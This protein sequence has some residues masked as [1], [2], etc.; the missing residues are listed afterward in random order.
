[1]TDDDRGAAGG[2]ERQR[3]LEADPALGLAGGHQRLGGRRAV[4]QDLEVDAGVVV[5]ALRL[6]R[7][8]SR[9]GSCSASSRARGGPCRAAPRTP[10]ATRRHGRRAE[11]RRRGRRR[12]G[13][14]STATPTSPDAARGRR[15]AHGAGEREAASTRYRWMG[16]GHRVSSSNMRNAVS[17][18]GDGVSRVDGPA[19]F[20]GT[21]RIR[22]RGS[23]AVRHTL[24]ARGA[25][26]RRYSVVARWYTVRSAPAIRATSAD[27]A[28]GVER[29]RSTSRSTSARVPGGRVDETSDRL[30]GRRVLALGLAAPAVL[31][32]DPTFDHVEPGPDGLQRRRHGPGRRHGRRRLRD[33]RHGD[34][35][36]RR[37]DRGRDRRPRRSSKAP[38]G[39]GLRGRRLARDRRRDAPS[40]G[41][42]RTLDTTV[43]ADPAATI[44]GSDGQPRCGPRSRRA[45]SSRRRSSCSCSGSSLVTIV[46]GL[47]L[48][49]L[50]ARQV[51]TA[52]ALI[53]REPGQTL[54][55]GLAGL[56]VV[57]VVAILAMIT[58]IGAPAR[59]GHPVHGLAG[60]RLRRLPRRRDLDRRMA[61]RPRRARRAPG[62]AVPGGRRRAARPAD[63]QPR[64]VR[65]RDRQPVRVRRRPA[66]GLADVP[67]AV[68]GTARSSARRR[69]SRWASDRLDGTAASDRPARPTA[70]APVARVPQ[71]GDDLVDDRR[72]FGL[73]V[74]LVAEARVGPALDARCAFEHVRGGRPGRARRP[75]RAGR[76]SGSP[77]PPPALAPDP[78]LLAS[79]SAPKRD[80]ADLDARA[81]RRPAFAPTVGS[82]DRVSPSM[83]LGIERGRRDAGQD[84]RQPLLPA[85][86]RRIERRR[87][88]HREVRLRPVGQEV[89]GGDQPTER[90]AVEH[91]RSPAASARDDR[92]SRS[93]RSSWSCDQRSTS[94]R[95]PP[96]PPMPRWS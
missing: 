47:A 2:G 38:G 90:V 7:R 89:A 41:D 88:E 72:A 67:P 40:R 70:G 23:V 66:P 24:S 28:R 81:G 58:I 29:S 27:D 96:E 4:R 62:T 68:R 49:A 56:V 82:R 79:A 37:R 75:G 34:D 57:P 48:A 11:A 91:D 93:A 51:R 59:P 1:M 84:A 45:P 26:R 80:G 30:P 65:R 60:R 3:V 71:P 54:L 94:P 6:R 31:A 87:R 14:E 85:R 5:P 86:E 52:E 77:N 35:P 53:S 95:R 18:T 83:P 10:T 64:A 50:G 46:A 78:R 42:I 44:G 8:R 12:R 39:V 9:C 21:S 63:R 20:A 36:W 16:A 15:R 74:E 61:A 13:A 76:G 69:P 43:S 19:S 25:P 32:A 22:F 55:V 17:G 92:A 33:R 73:V